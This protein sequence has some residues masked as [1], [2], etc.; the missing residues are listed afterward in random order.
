MDR[1]HSCLFPVQPPLLNTKPPPAT[2]W[3]L[4]SFGWYRWSDRWVALTLSIPFWKWS[5]ESE[6]AYYA[7]PCSLAKD[8]SCDSFSIHSSPVWPLSTRALVPP[9]TQVLWPQANLGCC[10]G[11]FH[12][13]H[14]GLS[15]VGSRRYITEK[16]PRICTPTWD[17]QFCAIEGA[18]IMPWSWKRGCRVWNFTPSRSLGIQIQNENIV[19]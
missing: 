12:I 16:H 19:Q 4:S 18:G 14:V 9:A 1:R 17:N 3:N 15:S 6:F 11:T 10:P 5:G 2:L 8:N 7:N 13:L